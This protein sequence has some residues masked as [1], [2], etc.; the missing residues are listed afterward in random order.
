MHV[1]QIREEKR[2]RILAVT[3]PDGSGRIQ[4]VNKVVVRT[5]YQLIELFYPLN[6][7]TSVPTFTIR[8]NVTP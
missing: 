7:I 4:T 1:Y 8:L 5:Y 6:N 3:H 2:L